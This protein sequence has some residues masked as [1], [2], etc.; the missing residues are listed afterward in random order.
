MAHHPF[1]Q[2]NKTMNI[3]QQD[4][5]AIVSSNINTSMRYMHTYIPVHTHGSITTHASC[6]QLIS[7]HTRSSCF[8][9]FSTMNFKNVIHD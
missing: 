5:C 9:F 7:I 2:F 1:I 8:F 6:A 4:F 3:K